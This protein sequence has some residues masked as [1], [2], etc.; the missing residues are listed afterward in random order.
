[1]RD[2]YIKLIKE[3]V[4]LRPDYKHTLNEIRAHVLLIG[5]TEEE[6][7]KAMQDLTGIPNA[8]AMLQ[9]KDQVVPSASDDPITKVEKEVKIH[10]KLSIVAACILLFIVGSGIFLATLTGKSNQSTIL[11]KKIVLP[12]SA[13]S[14]QEVYASTFAINGQQVFSYPAKNKVQLAVP[15]KPQKQIVG[16]FPYW[17]LDEAQNITLTPYTQLNLFSIDMD[18][19]GNVVSIDS[20][21]TPDGGWSMWNDDNLNPLIQKAKAQNVKV[22][23]TFRSFDNSDI[24]QLVASDDN[25]KR[26]I[27]NAL[28]MVNEK[29]LDGIN[30]DFEYVGTPSDATQLGFTRFIT[31]LHTELLRQ[32]PGSLLTIDTYISSGQTPNL[33]DISS[34]VDVSDALII[35]GYDVHTPGGDPG[36]IAPMQGDSNIIG[37]MQ[38]YLEKVPATKLILAVPYYG[39]DWPLPEANGADSGEQVQMVPYAEIIANTG[40]YKIQWDPN[41]ETPWYTYIDSSN[42]THEVHFE[43]VRSLGIKY[44]YINEKGLQG[45]GVWALGYEGNNNDLD[46]LIINKFSQ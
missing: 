31:N 24:E 30:I 32:D 17:M 12:K 9:T 46:N 22:L 27:A 44:D 38:N 3:Y 39:Y 21:G 7:N 37:F 40:Q 13:K 28:Y 25:Q 19:K 42:V 26:F 6:F 35:M 2:D 33:F 23:L 1:M 34:L 16:F 15:N 11:S 45:V 18:G 8:V 5:A 10:K 20:S 43:D 4:G 36:S 29:N 14:L 41:S